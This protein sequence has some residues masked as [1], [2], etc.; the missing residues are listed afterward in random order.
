[1]LF[2]VCGSLCIYIDFTTAVLI[3]VG[4]FRF[5]SSKTKRNIGQSPI[6]CEQVWR[7]ANIPAHKAAHR[8]GFD[9][10]RR[11]DSESLLFCEKKTTY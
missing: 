6:N 8:R 2:L 10:S 11:A 5:D 1:M 7:C 9:S 3:I 4:F